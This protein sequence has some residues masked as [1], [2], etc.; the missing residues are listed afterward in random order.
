MVVS[1]PSLLPGDGLL[2]ISAPKMP[3]YHSHHL[4]RSTSFSPTSRLTAR[5]VR[6]CSAP[7]I[8]GVSPMML[9]PPWATRRSE[10]TPRAGVAVTPL[11]PAEPPPLVPRMI[12]WAHR[13]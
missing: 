10:A 5:R 6:R 3:V 9:V 4:M 8:S 1:P 13:L 12:L 2:L 11:L 7:Y